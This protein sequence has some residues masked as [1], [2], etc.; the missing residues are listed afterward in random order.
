[1][2][3]KR[4][5]RSLMNAKILGGGEFKIVEDQEDTTQFFTM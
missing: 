3:I 2:S 1:M 4:T 5:Q